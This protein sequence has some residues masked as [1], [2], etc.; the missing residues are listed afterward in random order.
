MLAALIQ[1]IIP[2]VKRLARAISASSPTSLSAHGDGARFG[3]GAVRVGPAGAQTAERTC[4]ACCCPFCLSIFSSA[5][6]NVLRCLMWSSCWSLALIN[7]IVSFLISFWSLWTII[8]SCSLEFLSLKIISFSLKHKS[9]FKYTIHIKKTK[10]VLNTKL[11]E[12]VKR[13]ICK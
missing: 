7:S 2:Q 13:K 10:T 12:E 3:R 8:S 4:A 6:S 1:E 11:R 9:H 5:F